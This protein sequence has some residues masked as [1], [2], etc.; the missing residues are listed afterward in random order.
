MLLRTSQAFV[1]AGK[2]VVFF[3]AVPDVGFDVPTV[4]A[5]AAHNQGQSASKGIRRDNSVA[6]ELDAFFNGVAGELENVEY[7]NIWR[8]F[9]DLKC[10]LL[11]SGI[12]LYKGSNHLT[13]SASRDF[14]GPAVTA[15]LLGVGFR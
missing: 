2:N 10:S 8:D 9:C 13:L 14:M 12:P 5:L 4:L 15:G 6:A 7:I 1:Q 3:G 11:Q